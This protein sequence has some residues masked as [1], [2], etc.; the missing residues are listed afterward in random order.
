MFLT[1]TALICMHCTCVLA[2]GPITGFQMP[3]GKGTVA[4]G[5]SWEAYDT[6]LGAEGVPEDRDVE[7]TSYFL[8]GEFGLSDKTS[9]VLT[10][11]YLEVND[12]AGSLQDASVWLKY[13]NLDDRAENGA[14]RL[15]TAVGLS[16]P[17]GDYETA[18]I[19]AIGQQ[20]TIFQ[21]RLV[22]Q[23]QHDQGWFLNAMSGIDF[24]FAPEARSTWPVL[25]RGGWGGKHLYTEGWVEFIT[26]IQSGTANQ[27]AIGGS[28]SSWSR[29]GLTLYV[30]AWEWLGFK[31]GGAWVL[32]GEFIGR[33]DRLDVGVIFNY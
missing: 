2:Q 23:W 12:A 9:V 10:L 13:L 33:S 26:A 1:T 32:G 31:V 7:T 30:P 22:Y 20:A 3:K 5:Y 27:T 17:V 18:G 24:Q 25:L 21:G 15:F 29:A 28:G 6:Y 16:F 4:L 14:H 11:P 19:A 8:F